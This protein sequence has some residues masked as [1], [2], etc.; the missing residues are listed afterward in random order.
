M[1]APVPEEE[2]AA[3]DVDEAPDDEHDDDLPDESDGGQ[4]AQ[5]TQ[6]EN[7]GTSLDQPSS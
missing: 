6:A 5:A 3:F 2:N 4:A 1:T 7:A